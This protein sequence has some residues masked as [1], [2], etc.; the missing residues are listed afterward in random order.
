MKS[1]GHRSGLCALRKCW[2]VVVYIA[3]SGLLAGKLVAEATGSCPQARSCEVLHAEEYRDIR[4]MGD[5]MSASVED[6]KQEKLVWNQPPATVLQ[7]RDLNPNN[8]R[9]HRK[10]KSFA[11][12]IIVTMD[13]GKRV[14]L[15]YFQPE[16]IGLSCRDLASFD[17]VILPEFLEAEH[18]PCNYSTELSSSPPRLV[19]SVPL[20]TSVYEKRWENDDRSREEVTFELFGLT[21]DD[22]RRAYPMLR[23]RKKFELPLKE[24]NH[25]SLEE[26]MLT[27]GLP[28]LQQLEENNAAHRKDVDVTIRTGDI[29]VTAHASQAV[30]APVLILRLEIA[31]DLIETGPAGDF[32]L[33]LWFDRASVSGQQSAPAAADSLHADRWR[34]QTMDTELTDGDGR[35]QSITFTI[36]LTHD[37]DE[38]LAQR[39]YKLLSLPNLTWPGRRHVMVTS[40]AMAE[41]YKHAHTAYTGG[42]HLKAMVE[43]VYSKSSMATWTQISSIHLPGCRDIGWPDPILG[44]QMNGNTGTAVKEF[45]MC[46]VC[47]PPA[48]AAEDLNWC[49]SEPNILNVTWNNTMPSDLVRFYTLRADIIGIHNQVIASISDTIEVPG[50]PSLMSRAYLIGDAPIL[51]FVHQVV[52]VE[53]AA[54]CQHPFTKQNASQQMRLASMQE[55]GDHRAFCNDPDRQLSSLPPSIS[56]SSGYTTEHTESP[57]SST[58]ENGIGQATASSSSRRASSGI[59]LAAASSVSGLLLLVIGITLYILRR[60][61]RTNMLRNQDDK[62]G[63][64]YSMIAQPVSCFGLSSG[65]GE[66]TWLKKT[67]VVGSSGGGQHNS[68][69]HSPPQLYYRTPTP[70]LSDRGGERHRLEC[71]KSPLIYIAHDQACSASVDVVE[72][73]LAWFAIRTM[74]AKYCPL[75]APGSAAKWTKDTIKDSDFLLAVISDNFPRS[76]QSVGDAPSVDLD[77]VS[78]IERELHDVETSM[79]RSLWSRPKRKSSSQSPV[80]LCAYLKPYR[81]SMQCGQPRGVDK[82]DKYDIDPRALYHDFASEEFCP[83]M[84]TLIYRLY[85]VDEQT[86]EII[87]PSPRCQTSPAYE[88]DGSTGV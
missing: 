40:R 4:Q 60:R 58:S 64:P 50:E 28:A 83:G 42:M 79:L 55:A 14:N 32:Y 84:R 8:I 47:V 24:C 36:L 63:R 67:S 31:R 9:R 10:A 38:G 20:L 3:L 87:F 33:T 39:C 43:K 15:F 69:H 56:P 62:N 13:E 19:L 52:I 22:P 21:H 1:P 82:S 2:L 51:P 45:P 71:G 66:Q 74:R 65:G 35:P 70:A 73:V 11:A 12:K 18:S 48:T 54:V 72:Q 80:P 37:I 53:L 61:H 23:L 88:W 41:A 59:V 81:S 75:D 76:Q 78:D 17:V 85:S 34:L 77:E 30:K 49:L 5:E 44:W 29:G 57:A 27:Y 46:T 26:A 86:V 6:V 25:E 16:Q 68:G 7:I